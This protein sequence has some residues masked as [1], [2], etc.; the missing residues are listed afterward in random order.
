MFLFVIFTCT[1][2]LY[3]FCKAEKYLELNKNRGNILK[4]LSVP[5]NS[6]SK[7]RSVSRQNSTISHRSN[8]VVNSPNVTFPLN[9]S[10]SAFY[11]NR[12]FSNTEYPNLDDQIVNSSS[13]T[14]IVNEDE[15]NQE[16]PT[17]D[18]YKYAMFR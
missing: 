14:Y 18:Y 16:N 7:S 11:L 13:L 1:I 15:F 4:N 6:C 17:S 8:N 3:F 2:L 12:V 9:T 5:G 10:N